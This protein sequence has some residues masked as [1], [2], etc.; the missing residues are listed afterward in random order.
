MTDCEQKI[1]WLA[2]AKDALHR[3]QLGGNVTLRRFGDKQINYGAANETSL[4]AYLRD[5]QNAVDA[6]N[7]VP[8]VPGG[9]VVHFMPVDC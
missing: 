2:E 3:L 8:R 5:L 9:G 6:C 7:G 4:R 1:L